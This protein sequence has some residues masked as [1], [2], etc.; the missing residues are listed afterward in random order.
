MPMNHQDKKK[1]YIENLSANVKIFPRFLTRTKS[2][3]ELNFRLF[4]FA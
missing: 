2:N 3:N 4:T 1:T